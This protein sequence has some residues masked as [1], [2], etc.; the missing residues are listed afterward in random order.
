[1][2]LCSAPPSSWSNGGNKD[3]AREVGKA[4][5]KAAHMA[6]GIENVVFDRGGYLYHARASCGR[7]P[8]G[9]PEF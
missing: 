1:M 3:A 8:R 2:T 7:R 5:A 9:R 4:V 6:K